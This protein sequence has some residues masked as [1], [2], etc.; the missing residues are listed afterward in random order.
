MQSQNRLIGKTISGVITRPAGRGQNPALVMLQFD[1]GTYFEF[2]SPRALKSL[3]NNRNTTAQSVVAEAMA[4]AV[5][6]HDQLMMFG[7]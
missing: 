7:V 6:G 2:V 1:D 5:S 3:T 4:G